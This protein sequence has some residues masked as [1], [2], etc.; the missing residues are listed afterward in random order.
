MLERRG[1]RAPEEGRVARIAW[2]RRRAERPRSCA[3]CRD[4]VAPGEGAECPR[5]AAVL[6]PA[7]RE[8][9]GRCPT[10]GCGEAA[11]APPAWR[12]HRSE[13]PTD[14][15]RLLP[16]GVGLA[17][18]AGAAA[19]VL[20][21]AMVLVGLAHEAPAAQFALEGLLVAAL[22]WVASHAQP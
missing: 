16:P 21:A 22:A 10:L 7:C 20:H 13:G 17:V 1:R 8:E 14:D 18:G 4:D 15:G 19:V 5:C 2:G 12:T 3:F 11:E 6:H 9:L